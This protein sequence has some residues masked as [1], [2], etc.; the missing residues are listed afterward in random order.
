ML[1]VKSTGVNCTSPNNTKILSCSS[2]VV[3]TG[4]AQCVFP[5]PTVASHTSVHP[6][7]RRENI[8]WTAG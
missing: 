5:I 4:T 2:V 8:V 3:C 6:Q 7:S 1:V